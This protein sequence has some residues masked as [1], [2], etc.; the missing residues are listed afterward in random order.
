MLKKIN[1]LGSSNSIKNSI[2]TLLKG[3]VLAQGLPILCTP[4]LTRL[5]SP[6]SFGIFTLY[7]SLVLSLVS[8][9]GLR[10]EYGILL[11]RNDNIAWQLLIMSA[12]IM[13]LI[14]LLASF[15]IITFSIQISTILQNPALTPWLMLV[16]INILVLGLTQLITFWFNRN[17]QYSLM[18]N[19]RMLQS[20]TSNAAQIT[21]GL[22][23]HFG[24]SGLI[25]GNLLGQIITLISSL[26]NILPYHQRKRKVLNIE[27]KLLIHYKS[28]PLYNAPTAL[29][30]ALRLNGINVLLSTFFT[31]SSL[32]QFALAWR[33]L[34]SPISLINGALSQVYY[35]QFTQ[36]A[37]TEQYSFLFTCIKKSFIIGIIPFTLL[38]FTAEWLFIIFF[39]IE[40]KQA[41][42]ICS[43]LVPWL[44]LNFITSPISSIYVV[45]KQEKT[46]LIFSIF[47]MLIPLGIIFYIHTN[48][49]ETLVYVSSAMSLLLL[50]FIVIALHLT[51]T[52]AK[53]K[54]INTSH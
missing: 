47:Y 50:V 37:L 18:A 46:L 39:G 17:K 20:A 13:V 14:S 3:S 49:I 27:K 16:G 21:L 54:I 51:K 38:Y 45:L 44:F 43:T 52:Y 15:I 2:L 42:Q 1:S 5:Y 53:E 8:I 22:G 26:M 12:K 4:I 35:Q 10:Y 29:I 48:I 33:L 25:I 34:Q 6:D 7:T 19:Q 32:G 23:F 36:L 9:V 41:G 30:D 31:V 28:L 24:V 40:W 11:P